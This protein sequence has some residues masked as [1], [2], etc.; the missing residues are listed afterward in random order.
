MVE[1]GVD[2]NRLKA[3]SF[4]ENKP[5]VVKQEDQDK[6]PFLKVGDVLNKAFIYKLPTEKQKQVAMQMNRRT[7][8]KIERIYKKPKSRFDKSKR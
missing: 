8:I 1:Q 7:E 6:Y 2:E 5:W 3:L 4:G